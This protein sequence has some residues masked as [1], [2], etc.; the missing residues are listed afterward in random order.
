M[1]KIPTL[2]VRN[3]DNMREILPQL[4][5]DCGWVL[6]G[7]GIATRK[8]DG[9]CVLARRVLGSPTAE[10][11]WFARREVKP[12]QTAP[13]SFEPISTDE[14]TGKIMGW[15]PYQESGFARYLDEVISQDRYYGPGTYELCG[16]KINSNPERFDQ[17]TLIRH[18]DAE[19]HP[20]YDDLPPDPAEAFEFLRHELQDSPGYEG[21]VWHHPDG[22][23]AKLK[24]RDFQ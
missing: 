19:R 5:P 22:R 1:N 18:A 9:T 3:P 8:Y 12:N 6:V 23:M 11:E 4:H 20:W 17:H 7:E 2:F 21:V 24:R 16:P 14:V 10:V 15:I 13:A